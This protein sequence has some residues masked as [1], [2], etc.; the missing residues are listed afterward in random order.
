MWCD[1]CGKHAY[2]TVQKAALSLNFCGNHGKRFQDRLKAE[3]WTVT[4][5]TE[6]YESLARGAKVPA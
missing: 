3:G 2:V 6:A 4:W 5:D 1:R